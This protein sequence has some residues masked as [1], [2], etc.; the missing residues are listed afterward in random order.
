MDAYSRYNQLRMSESDASH[1]TF[2]VGSDIYHYTVMPFGQLNVIATY[3]PMVS[4][5]FASMICITTKAYVD[6]MLV[7]FIRGVDH[8][9]DLRKTFKR[10]RHH[11]AKCA[12]CIQSRKFLGYM[13]S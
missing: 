13:V 10:I 2:Y 4:K 5:L 7:R 8:A 9:E 1:T 6:S 3:H 11:P 12:F